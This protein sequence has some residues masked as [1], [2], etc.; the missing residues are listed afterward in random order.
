MADEVQLW[1]RS[2]S[3]NR[4][5]GTCGQPYIVDHPHQLPPASSTQIAELND[6]MSTSLPERNYFG[7]RY[8]FESGPSN[9][10]FIRTTIDADKLSGPPSLTNA[11]VDE[12][13]GVY[14]IRLMARGMVG[15]SAGDRA[16]RTAHLL[17]S[18][19]ITP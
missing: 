5:D 16:R 14:L 15:P 11:S 9:R 3:P 4:C 12:F 1:A 6:R 8:Y 13:N 18:P 7:G 19:R 2:G 10:L 17:A